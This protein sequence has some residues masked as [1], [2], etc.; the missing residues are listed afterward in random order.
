MSDDNADREL[1]VKKLKQRADVVRWGRE[2]DRLLAL[3]S[4]FMDAAE[5]ESM[6]GF[7]YKALGL[8]DKML[9]RLKGLTEAAR[10]VTA[11]KVAYDKAEKTLGEGLTPAQERE[12]VRKWVMGMEVQDRRNFLVSLLQSHR[13]Q[14]ADM[15]AKQS[16][17][18]NQIRPQPEEVDEPPDDAN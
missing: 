5:A 9:R 8:D 3:F 7:G 4:H 11:A 12:W 2:L 6:A 17:D 15:P 1:A 16:V 14:R 10:A 13:K 18:G